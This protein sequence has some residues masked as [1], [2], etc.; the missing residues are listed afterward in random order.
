MARRQQKSDFTLEMEKVLAERSKTD[1]KFARTVELSKHFDMK[2]SD[3][4]RK[5]KKKGFTRMEVAEH[6]DL[7]R[8]WF[9]K[10]YRFLN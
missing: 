5:A 6:L 2:L 4:F 3:L 9:Q 8:S 7:P 10:H 1:P